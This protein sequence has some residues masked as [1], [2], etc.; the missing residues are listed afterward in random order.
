[1]LYLNKTDEA[2]HAYTLHILY[3]IYNAF[4]NSHTFLCPIHAMGIRAGLEE[5]F[6]ED[7][8]VHIGLQKKMNITAYVKNIFQ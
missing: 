3:I 5:I 4:D 2:L 7:R 6:I 1:M 8:C